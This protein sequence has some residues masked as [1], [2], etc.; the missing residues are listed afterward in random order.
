MLWN[1]IHI[2]L[3]F[4]DAKYANE[5]TAD[6]IWFAGII[7]GTILLKKPFT[8]LL[9][10]LSNV[11]AKI[12]TGKTN[13]QSRL[14]LLIHEPVGK[15]LQTILIYIA[16]DQLNWLS[17]RVAWHPFMSSKGTVAYLD[18]FI[19]HVFLFLFIIFLTQ[20]VTRLVDFIYQL[21]LEKARRENNK[22]RV[23][24]LPLIKEIGKLL[25]WAIALFWILGSVFHVN[26][27]ALVTGLGIGGVAIALAAKESVENFFAAFT[28]L[29]DKPFEIGDTIRIGGNIEGVAERIGFRST[30]I[31]TS[32]GA[33]H[34]IP[35]QKLVSENL[36]NLSRRNVRIVKVA[37][38]VKYGIANDALKK[39]IDELKE[40][41]KNVQYVKEPVDALLENFNKNTARI[42]ISYS[43]PHPLPQGTGVDKVKQDV[44]LLIHD[45][46]SRYAAFY[47]SN[48]DDTSD[49]D[50]TTS[51]E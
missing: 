12:F 38:H 51:E 46:V 50:K 18:S 29:S 35:N 26:I 45:I 23:Q 19:D 10:R 25:A 3:D 31:R 24:F 27:P 42:N 4:F 49:D 47:V 40:T 34:I 14:G 28:I 33:A 36:A 15:L 37:V 21:N 9:S 6:Y 5:K 2:N 41:L 11:I 20:L 48:A 44:N 32:D 13:Y 39:M 8:R 16:F 30:R 17:H 43:L 1:V 22:E 7:L